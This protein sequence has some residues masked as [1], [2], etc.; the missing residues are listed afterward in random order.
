MDIQRSDPM[1]DY[2][3]AV[4]A[5]NPRF[6][7][8]FDAADESLSDAIQTVFPLETEYALIVWNWIYIPLSYKYDISMMARDLIDLIEL[9]SSSESGRRTIQWP[10]NT[11]ASTWNIAW[12]N[13]LTTVNAEWE[14]VL[15]ETESM[16]AAKPII[17]LRTADFISEWKRLLET[18]VGAL[19]AAG[20][21]SEHL[22]EMRL[23]KDVVGEIKHD[24][25]LY[26]GSTTG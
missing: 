12:S 13:E 3:F 20:Y 25:L 19:T 18:V 10:S 21:T 17:R 23:L 5:S 14:C 8:T 9:M 11:F 15:G 26:R 7:S 2:R 4:Q 22:V 24:G 6:I 1:N 16:L